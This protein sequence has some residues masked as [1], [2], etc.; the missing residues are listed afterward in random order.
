MGKSRRTLLVITLCFLPSIFSGLS[1]RDEL[2]LMDPISE[3]IGWGDLMLHLEHWM[4]VPPT[5][6]KAPRARINSMK[7]ATDGSGRLFLNDLRGPLYSIKN[8]KLTTYLDLREH[9]PRFYDERG[10]GGGLN[11]YEF[12]PEF[13]TNGLFYTTHSEEPSAEVPDFIG[14]RGQPGT[15]IDSVILEWKATNPNA[16]TFEGSFRQLMRV[17]FP[18]H[19]HF[20]QDMVFNPHA[21]PGDEDF[22]LLYIGVGEGG[23]LIAGQADFLNRTDSIWGTIIRIDPLGSNSAN[24]QYGFPD[25]NPWASDGDDKTLGELWAI[26]FRNPHRF[27]WGS[28]GRLFATDIGETNVE[29]INLIEKGRNYGW[30]HREGTFEFQLDHNK[31]GLLPLPENDKGYTYPVAQFDH[32]DANAISGGYVYEGTKHPLLKGKYVFGAI[33]RGHLFYT[34]ATELKFGQQAPIKKFRLSIGGKETSMAKLAGAARV[35]LRI[36]MDQDH[37]LYVFEKNKG[38]IFKITGVTQSS[39]R[40]N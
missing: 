30:P 24:G 16:P 39:H 14:P 38:Q 9:L 22:G 34:E 36:G 12:H 6:K 26:G 17:R 40:S 20:I 7:P 5:S 10:L 37:E 4:T 27:A 15:S 35:D 2:P 33:V 25:T 28:D 29:E 23:S 19:I 13:E 31:L 11:F 21:K 1:A 18:I 8:G 3:P 32:R